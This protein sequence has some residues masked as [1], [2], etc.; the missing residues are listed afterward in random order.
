MGD[1]GIEWNDITIYLTNIGS[2]DVDWIHLAKGR[3][4]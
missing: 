3:I 1:L 4:Q 2:G